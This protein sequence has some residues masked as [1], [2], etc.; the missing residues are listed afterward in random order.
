MASFGWAWWRL[1]RAAP[2]CAPGAACSPWLLRQRRLF[3]IL[4]GAGALL[5]AFRWYAP[6]F[7]R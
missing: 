5:V 2:A 1:Y 6:L 4:L 7:M 3:W